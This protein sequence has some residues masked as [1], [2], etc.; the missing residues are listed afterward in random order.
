[1]P[2]L[3]CICGANINLSQVPNQQGFKVIAEPILE[4]FLESVSTAASTSPSK[5]EL[6]K[7]IYRGFYLNTP[8]ILQVYE[9]NVCG[10]IA[11]FGKASQDVPD[12]WYKQESRSS[13]KTA[14]LAAL[15]QKQINEKSAN[16]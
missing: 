6:E 16:G 14:S 15:A 9:C 2:K 4:D 13:E 7:Q 5:N 12:F 3:S 1:M 8:G 10:R 11:I